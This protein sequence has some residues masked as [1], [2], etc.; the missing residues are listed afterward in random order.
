MREQQC[1]QHRQSEQAGGEVRQ[2]VEGEVQVHQMRQGGHR[3]GQR[4]EKTRQGFTLGVIK[5]VSFNEKGK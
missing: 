1:G 4:G 2:L 5:E 3:H